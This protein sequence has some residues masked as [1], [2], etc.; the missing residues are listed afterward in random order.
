MRNSDRIDIFCD[1]LKTL[2]KEKTDLRFGQIIE[3]IK[4]QNQIEDLFY[5]PDNKFEKLLKEYFK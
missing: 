1:L 4:I 2:W 3:G 5:I